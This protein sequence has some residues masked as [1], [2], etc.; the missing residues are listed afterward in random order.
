MGHCYVNNFVNI[1]YFVMNLLW[2]LTLCTGLHEH[3]LVRYYKKYG[4]K[5]KHFDINI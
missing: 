1:K 5:V 3:F 4:W 2:I